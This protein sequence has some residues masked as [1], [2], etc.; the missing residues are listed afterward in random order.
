MNLVS[1]SEL[2]R[3]LDVPLS[4]ILKARR[5]GRLTPVQII[6]GKILVFDLEQAEA[7]FRPIPQIQA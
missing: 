2:G 5:T 7:I 4:R 6:G 1:Q 3:K